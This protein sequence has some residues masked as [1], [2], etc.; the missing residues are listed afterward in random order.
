MDTLT[1]DRRSPFTLPVDPFIR[2]AYLR[3]KIG[4]HVVLSSGDFEVTGMLVS[5]IEPAKYADRPVPVVVI[6]TGVERV[7]G[8]VLEG[9]RL[10]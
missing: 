7:A 4:S 9:D 3:A 6:D 8:P 1:V 2:S 10:A 5:V